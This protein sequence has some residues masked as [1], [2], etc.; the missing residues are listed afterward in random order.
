MLEP[1][2]SVLEAH[3]RDWKRPG[4]EVRWAKRP[5][6]RARG[7][8]PSATSDARRQRQTIFHEL[9]PHSIPRE[10]PFPQFAIPRERS[11]IAGSAQGDSHPDY[12]GLH[13]AREKREPRPRLIRFLERR[14]KGRTRL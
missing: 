13:A 11:P 3:P 6:V 2:R 9:D 5:G 1:L 10:R 8:H 7:E 12:P 14:T 4:A